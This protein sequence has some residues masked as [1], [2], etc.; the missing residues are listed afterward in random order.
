MNA[1]FL[2]KQHPLWQ[3]GALHCKKR[4]EETIDCTSFVL[5]ADHPTRFAFLPG[6]FITIGVEI[7]GKKHYRAYSISSTP[8]EDDFLTITVK[9]VAGGLISNYLIDHFRTGESLDALAPA[10]EF[11]LPQNAEKMKH[12]MLSAGSGITPM[13]S[14]ARWL[15]A[16]NLDAD[17]HFIHS[18]R[19]EQELIFRDELLLIA[20]QYPTFKLDLFLTKPEGSVPCH[21]GR[22]TPERLTALLPDATDSDIYLCG[23]QEYMDMAEGWHKTQSLPLERFHKESFTPAELPHANPGAEMFTLSVPAFDK[24]AQI[25]DGQSLLEIMEAESL[26]IIGACRSGICGSC[27]CKVIEGKVEQLSTETL[28]QDEIDSGV[29]LAC[30]TVARGS[31]KVEIV[32]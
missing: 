10:G 27:K 30:S 29:V 7:D 13:M 21:T 5:T 24:T 8:L 19:S 32:F 14:M 26:P 6:Q 1:V 11:H 16:H 12:V 9:R 23:H 31:L 15:L 4:I 3:G 28:T 2:A 17:I 18:A 22:L 20:Q 25:A